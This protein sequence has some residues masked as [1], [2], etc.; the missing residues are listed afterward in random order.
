MVR[1]NKTF[2]QALADRDREIVTLGDKLNGLK[3]QVDKKAKI[4]EKCRSLERQ[5]HAADDQIKNLQASLSDKERLCNRLEADLAA[6]NE[7][8][9]GDGRESTRIAELQQDKDRLE[10]AFRQSKRD[11]REHEEEVKRVKQEL[12]A[13][14]K[15]AQEYEHKYA[16]EVRKAFA[17][18][19]R[20]LLCASDRCICIHIYALYRS[21]GSRRGESGLRSAR[22]RLRR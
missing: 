5:M 15:R 14:L 2:K 1:E 21:V 18:R 10:D 20:F 4:D 7:S 12:S 8:S 17:D 3:D 11:A 19:I 6:R 22:P 16:E 9:G 13:A